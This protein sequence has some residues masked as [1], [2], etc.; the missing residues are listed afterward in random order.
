MLRYSWRSITS[1]YR[2][3][4]GSSVQR[5]RKMTLLRLG[6]LHFRKGSRWVLTASVKQRPRKWP[7]KSI[8]L[9]DSH[10]Y[11]KTLVP[12]THYLYHVDYP[13]PIHLAQLTIKNRNNVINA[14][15]PWMTTSTWFV[16]L[17]QQLTFSF[18]HDVL[19]QAVVRYCEVVQ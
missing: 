19:D 1:W 9:N 5:Q 13:I 18:L 14:Q 10:M 12:P 7:A 2:M 6:S 8:L 4:S 15:V 16:Y 11:F 3:N 17:A